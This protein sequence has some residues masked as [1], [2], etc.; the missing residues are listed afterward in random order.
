MSVSEMCSVKGSS[1]RNTA[2]K[3]NGPNKRCVKRAVLSR[4]EK[5]CFYDADRSTLSIKKREPCDADWWWWW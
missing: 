5:N 1:Y 2:G 3:Q 4:L